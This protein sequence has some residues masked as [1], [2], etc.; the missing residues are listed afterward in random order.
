MVLFELLFFVKDVISQIMQLDTVFIFIIIV[1]F[2]VVAYKIFSFLM[3]ALIV[4]LIFAGFPLAANFFGFDFPITLHSMLSSAMLGFV[5]FFVYSAVAT[6]FKIMGL[7][8][9][10]FR[11]KKGKTKVVYV[12]ERKEKKKGF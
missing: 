9:K 8:L 3:R 7:A 10:P 2:V 11:G 6:A 4:G 1:V 5:V 12:K